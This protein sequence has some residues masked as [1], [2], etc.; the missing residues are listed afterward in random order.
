MATNAGDVNNEFRTL[1]DS[2]QLTQIMQIFFQEWHLF[3]FGK[4]HMF[5]RSTEQH[6]APTK[7][8]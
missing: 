2:T 5:P 1:V 3:E 4:F 6:I 7:I 8:R